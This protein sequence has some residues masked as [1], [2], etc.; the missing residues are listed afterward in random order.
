LGLLQAEAGQ[1]ADHLDDRDLALAGRF[2]DD[3]ERRLLLCVGPVAA[4]A[5]GG[6]GGHGGRGRGGRHPAALLERLL[7]LNELEDRHLLEL[8]RRNRHVAL[9]RS[10]GLGRL[11]LLDVL[12]RTTRNSRSGAASTL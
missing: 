7:Q 9:L 5:T 10:G 3:V 6:R 8:L 11:S 12:V 1:L 2:E 4:T